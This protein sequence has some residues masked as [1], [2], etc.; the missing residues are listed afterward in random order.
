MK[1]IWIISFTYPIWKIRIRIYLND[2]KQQKS[3]LI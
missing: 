2:P 3:A 1:F